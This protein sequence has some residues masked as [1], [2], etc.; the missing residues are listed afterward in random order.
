MVHSKGIRSQF[1]NE[2]PWFVSR[3]GKFPSGDDFCKGTEKLSIPSEHSCAA[4]SHFT[5]GRE[6]RLFTVKLHLLRTA[7]ERLFLRSLRHIAP[8]PLP[9]TATEPSAVWQQNLP[10]R[11]SYW[12]ESPLCPRGPN[13]CWTNA[14]GKP[15]K[16]LNEWAGSMHHYR[17]KTSHCGGLLEVSPVTFWETLEATELFLFQTYWHHRWKEKKHTQLM[18]P[19]HTPML[20]EVS[21]N[22][23][24]NY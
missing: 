6:S 3:V 23:G 5:R 18:S 9:F 4:L 2:Q 15:S 16:I 19:Q 13:W 7:L 12:T 10:A 22:L 11:N 24:E 20:W 14:E 17:H 1:S 8:Y 21:Q